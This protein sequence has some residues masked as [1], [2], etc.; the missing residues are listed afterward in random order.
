VHPRQK[1]S[2]TLFSMDYASFDSSDREDYEFPWLEV[3]GSDFGPKF[4]SAVNTSRNKQFDYSFRA[5]MIST[6]SIGR[7]ASKVINSDS[8]FKTAYKQRV[9]LDLDAFAWSR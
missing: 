2:G 8:A 6:L 1:K 4:F 5:S 7:N 3:I 9:S